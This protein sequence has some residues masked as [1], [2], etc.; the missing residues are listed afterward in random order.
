MGKFHSVQRRESKL[1]FH[2]IHLFTTL[3]C[4]GEVVGDDSTGPFC[5]S[6]CLVTPKASSSS[7]LSVSPGGDW[8]FLPEEKTGFPAMCAF[9]LRNDHAEQTC[10]Y[11]GTTNS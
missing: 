1:S 3:S 5:V 8:V 7:M 9:A 6:S 4:L 11:V 2:I 10:A